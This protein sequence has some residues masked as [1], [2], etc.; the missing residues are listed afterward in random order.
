MITDTES[1][2]QRRP[3]RLITSDRCLFKLLI[4]LAK[5]HAPEKM[6]PKAVAEFAGSIVR[7]VPKGLD[8]DDLKCPSCGPSLL[9]KT[10]CATA[11]Q[12]LQPLNSALVKFAACIYDQLSGYI[13]LGYA[14]VILIKVLN[15]EAEFQQVQKG[16]HGWL[17]MSTPSFKEKF[18]KVVCILR[19]NCDADFKIVEDA[20]ALYGGF[21]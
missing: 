21:H 5:V 20:K 11:G 1:K 19:Q 12:E 18:G 3:D 10:L 14:N 8:L 15:L 17:L 16:T 4:R 2:T 13:S 7:S 6:Y 9:A